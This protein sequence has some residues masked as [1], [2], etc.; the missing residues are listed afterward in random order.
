MACVPAIVTG[1]L[2]IGLVVCPITKAFV[3]DMVVVAGII[4]TLKTAPCGG[5]PF[6]IPFNE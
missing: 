3:H 5:Q 6:I 2:I 4:S 1:I